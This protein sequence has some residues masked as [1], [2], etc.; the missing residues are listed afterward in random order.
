MAVN[1]HAIVEDIVRLRRS[2]EALNDRIAAAT[3]EKPLS[4]ADMQN[5]ENAQARAD[6]VCKTLSSRAPMPLAGEDARAYRVRVASQ[7]QR[8]S[9]DWSKADLHA[10]SKFA[11]VFDE[12]ERR[13][14]ADAQAAGLR[15]DFAPPGVLRSRKETDESG[16]EWTVYHGRPKTWMAQFM[17]PPQAV[18]GF[19]DAHGN[20]L[21]RGVRRP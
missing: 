11:E 3:R 19:Y 20:P 1:N 8:F 18:L 12:A 14:Y 4:L 21:P 6:G 16:R 15:P 17:M 5:L 9:P 2:Q 13:I 7:L 10:I